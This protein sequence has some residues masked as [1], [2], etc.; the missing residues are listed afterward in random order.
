MRSKGSV[1][2]DKAASDSKPELTDAEQKERV[3]QAIQKREKMA[4]SNLEMAK[5]FLRNEKLDIARR[6]LRE[7]VSEFDGSTAATEAKVLLK[8]MKP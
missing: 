7:L 4:E 6:R 3:E 1:K 8:R 5:M 2:A